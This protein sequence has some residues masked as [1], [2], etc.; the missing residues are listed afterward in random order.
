MHDN[1]TTYEIGEKPMNT[2]E[3]SP[4]HYGNEASAISYDKQLQS[5]ELSSEAVKVAVETIHSNECMVP[6]HEADDGCIDG[7]CAATVSYF[8]DGQEI[9]APADN[10]NHE[11]YKVAG[12]GYITGTG[13]VLAL[14]EAYRQDTLDTQVAYTAALLN[15]K[16]IISGM[17]T[18]DV[19]GNST[20]TG[21]GA[22][23]QLPTILRNGSVFA[24]QISANIEAL[25]GVAGMTY[26][27]EVFSSVLA[28]WDEALEIEGFS[29]KSTGASRLSEMKKA[30]QLAQ[31]QSG[32]EK[33]VA[34]SKHLAGNHKEDFIVL[35]FV[36]GKTFSQDAFK[37]KLASA[38]AIDPSSEEAEEIAQSFVV[39]VP[40]IVAMSRALSTNEAG[41]TDNTRFETLLYA[42]VAYQLA[43]AATL[44]DGSLRTFVVQ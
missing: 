4:L 8:K 14:G 33:P 42:G 29:D 10:S 25:I 5:G 22:N 18:A 41:E 12:G 6:I 2:I 3:I 27:P 40:R 35:N 23:D 39:D 24:E 28:H 36:E 11:R 43:T 13:M 30:I 26:K 16:G 32:N 19:H 31:D 34:V 17:H 7:R 37:K 44:T 38:F 1:E 15:E 9:T 20:G 21:C